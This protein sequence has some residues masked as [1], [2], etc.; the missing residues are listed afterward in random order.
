MIKQ[1]IL[2]LFTFFLMA[3]LVIAAIWTQIIPDYRAEAEIRVRPIIPH[4]VFQT[5]DNGMI[6][7]Y[8]SFVNTQVS[9]MRSMTVLQRVLDQKAVQDTQWY[10]EPPVS[11][12]QRLQG[13]PPAPPI[14]RLRSSLTV[15]P[16]PK[17][18]IIDV[19]FMDSSPKDDAK[20]I[21]DAVLDQYIQYIGEKSDK[22][23]DN[24][25]A[26]LVEQYHK[27]DTE[28]SGRQKII[29]EL[30]KSLGTENP[31]E[32]ISSRRIRLDKTQARLS[33]LR[34]TIAVLEWE[35]KQTDNLESNADNN[36][37]NNVQD[38]SITEM[39]KKP[40][41]HEDSEWRV[42]DIN[43]RTIQ[44]NLTAS[45]F[46]PNNPETIRAT[47][48]MEFA[49]ELLRLREAQLDEQW[50]DRLKN[51]PEVP[52]TITS[53]S[54]PDYDEE[55]KTLEFQLDRAR[56]EEK[57]LIAELKK[58]QADFNQLSE[59]AQMLEKENNELQHKR[60]LFKA[61]RQRLDQK[62]MERNVSGTIEVLTPAFAPSE[63]HNDRRVLYTAIVVVLDSLGIILSA[64][65]LH[66]HGFL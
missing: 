7:L 25:Y 66:R 10:N 13:K 54:G 37:G 56:Q 22:T 17:S 42:L 58:Q 55:L 40:K 65:I 3:A 59:I 61:V 6:P 16:R 45:E 28:I 49:K 39:R 48:D 62:N 4:L 15:Q 41:Y 18:E 23:K 46:D 27:L 1:L 43:V 5:E 11:L 52:I 36:D 33:D 9:I 24:L 60:D 30:R 63:P 50:R 14:E 57:L 32:L 53:D 35:L 12:M 2:L 26:K 34:Q 21:V 64:C 29:T 20:I 8:E 31:Q 47:K 44:H 38:A 51:L 19:I